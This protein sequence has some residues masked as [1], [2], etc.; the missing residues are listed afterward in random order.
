MSELLQF[1]IVV[2]FGAGLAAP[3]CRIAAQVPANK[4]T[5]APRCGG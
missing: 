3:R 4:K 2:A 1:V 5:A